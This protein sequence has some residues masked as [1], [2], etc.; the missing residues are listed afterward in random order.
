MPQCCHVLTADIVLCRSVQDADNASHSE[1]ASTASASASAGSA[2]GAAAAAAAAAPPVRLQTAVLASG[3]SW[4]LRLKTATRPVSAPLLSA[5]QEAGKEAPTP[6]AMTDVE[7]PP[8]RA[9]AL[10]I[11]GPISSDTAAAAAP[12]QQQ[13]QQQSA[14]EVPSLERPAAQD[15][16]QGAAY[17]PA[18]GPAVS[19]LDPEV[20]LPAVPSG[21]GL[22]TSVSSS[23]LAPGSDAGLPA[24]AVS[25]VP[26][27]AA[28]MS[29][30]PRPPMARAYSG[31]FSAAPGAPVYGAAPGAA[32]AG[33]SPTAAATA[34]AAAEREGSTNM[35]G[36]MGATSGGLS[37]WTSSQS[38]P[39]YTPFGAPLVRRHDAAFLNDKHFLSKF[40]VLA[41][42]ESV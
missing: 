17:T 28:A 39:T 35:A 38:L 18:E 3:M 33:E 21:A 40:Q 31:R 4:A 42:R 1:E 19:A 29:Y 16:S 15:G 25:V 34:A 11:G 7:F 5:D 9:S 6:P 37:S 8:M 27:S 36:N 12:A 20:K 2:R 22:A 30:A 14:E 41:A 32:V 26:T 24:P 23:S 10:E 13:T